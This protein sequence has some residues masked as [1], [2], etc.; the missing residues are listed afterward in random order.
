MSLCRTQKKITL[1]KPLIFLFVFINLCLASQVQENTH[2]NFEEKNVGKTEKTQIILIH[3]T[4]GEE[5][6]WYQQNGTFYQKIEKNYK[7]KYPENS[8]EM[9]SF[10][11]S[12]ELSAISRMLASGN[13]VKVLLNAPNNITIGHSH[14]GNIVNL[15]SQIL[16]VIL[17]G[18]QSDHFGNYVLEL[19]Q[20]L[21]ES[22]DEEH[23][24]KA[25]YN[26]QNISLDEIKSE[27]SALVKNIANQYKNEIEKIKQLKA[28]ELFISGKTYFVIDQ[29]YL[30]AT[31]VNETWYLPCQD[32]VRNTYLLYSQ[33]DFVQTILPMYKS[34]YSHVHYHIKNLNTYFQ[35][36]E[37]EKEKIIIPSHSEMKAHEIADILLDI[38]ELI[39]HY[40]KH[41]LNLKIDI[42]K[43]A[44]FIKKKSSWSLFLSSF[45][46]IWKNFLDIFSSSSSVQE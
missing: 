43:E 29:S 24:K 5:S 17:M 18:D 19:A 12:G 8:F 38:P 34:K 23:K 35:F 21:K 1:L 37:N 2:Q 26:Q 36:I 15:A 45:E 28:R 25:T 9:I 10:S 41:D 32:T 44:A 42:D 31:P 20:M 40:P 39:T 7:E 13:L 4:F 16:K 11:W 3:G 6:E 27:L 46:I 30:L 22:E 33:G 14:G